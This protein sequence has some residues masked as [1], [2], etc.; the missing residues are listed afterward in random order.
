MQ[1]AVYVCAMIYV[2]LYKTKIRQIY[3]VIDPDN[4]LEW[5]SWASHNINNYQI[6]G[7][8][9]IYGVAPAINTYIWTL[10]GYSEHVFGRPSV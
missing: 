9:S 3:N 1:N 8:I 7:Q 10:A 2:V 5:S 6:M 4:A